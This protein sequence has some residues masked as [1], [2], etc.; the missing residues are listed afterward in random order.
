MGATE[1]R[2]SRTTMVGSVGKETAQSVTAR[3]LPPFP[4]H[5]NQSQSACK[6]FE[7][8]SYLCV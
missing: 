7:S 8:W 5:G 2:T 6:P 1:E 4:N 3:K